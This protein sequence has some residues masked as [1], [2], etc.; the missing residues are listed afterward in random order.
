VTADAFTRDSHLKHLDIVD[1]SKETL[2]LANFYS[3]PGHANP[4][5][6]PRVTIFIQDGR[7]FLQACPD[8]YDIITGEPPPLKTAATVNL[9]T[10]QFFSLMK[11]RLKDG[12]IASFWLPIYQVTMGDTKAIL[13]AFHNVFPSASVWATN[14]LEWIMIGIKPPLSKPDES[15]ARRL[16]NDRSTASDLVRI[17]VEV[18]E[19]MST[20]FVMDG[21]E[22]D[23]LTQSIEPLTDFFP[24]RLS[25]AEPDLVAAHQ[26]GY[27]YLDRS[28]AFRRFTTSPLIKEIWPG[29]WKRSLELYFGVR[30]TRYLSEI[31]G[32]NWLAELDLYLRYTRLRTPV[33]AAQDSDEFRLALAEK[34][35]NES[36]GPLPIEALRD[37]V[38]GALARR[39]FAGAIQL[40][41]QEKERGFPNINDLFLLTYLYCLNGKVEKAEALAAAEA[42]SIQKDWFVDWLWGDLQ[43]EFGFR[44]PS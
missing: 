22:I 34:L 4:L 3:V 24:K 13:R 16:W 1:I 19:Q 7:F 36:P 35:A 9:Y 10:E 32:S 27:S 14:D 8:R 33:L 26:F 41:E 29:E 30:E 20:L 17:G 38:A 11:S 40:L 2:S 18:P 12:G 23:R 43:A 44:P 42:G 5:R 25:D 21:K 15:L 28:A 37:L 31:S 6:D 39:D